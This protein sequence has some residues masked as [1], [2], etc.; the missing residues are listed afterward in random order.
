ML[1]LVYKTTN[2]VN[3]KFYIGSHQTQ[4]RDD[5]YLGS[6]TLLKR[7]IEK[8]GA[9][10][11]IREILFEANTSEEMF[12]KEKELVVLGPHTYNLKQGGFGGWDYAN[13]VKTPEQWKALQ[14]A[15]GKKARPFLGKTH[16]EKTKRICSEKS[17][18]AWRNGLM[19][20][21]FIGKRH[22]E[23]TKRKMSESQKGR[24]PWNKGK[25]L[26][27]DYKQK[28]SEGLKRYNNSR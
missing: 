28:I 11:F 14:S 26:S 6:G 24:I 15:G 25:T 27:D 23:E 9:N 4:D 22:S 7:A 18:E 12:Q 21:G 8:Y 10:N 16:T 5:G 13:N 2:L 20:N 1:Y 19:K 3:G 17:I